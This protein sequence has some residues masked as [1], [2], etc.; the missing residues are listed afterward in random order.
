MTNLMNQV[1]EYL[2][3]S[4]GH[5]WAEWIVEE[6]TGKLYMVEMAIR[7][8]G[9]YVTS[10]LIPR[11]YGIDTQEYLVKAALGEDVSDFSQ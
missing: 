3:P 6:K 2:K 11:T 9:A 7:G 4:Y 5:V 8:G 1:I 10:E